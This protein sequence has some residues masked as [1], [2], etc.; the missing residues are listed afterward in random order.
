MGIFLASLNVMCLNRTFDPKVSA[1]MSSVAVPYTFPALT[2]AAH[3]AS[4]SQGA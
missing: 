3:C 1:S 4:A 2:S